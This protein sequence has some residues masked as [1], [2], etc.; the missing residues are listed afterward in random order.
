MRKLY[1]QYFR[2]SENEKV[3]EKVLY[4][5][6]GVT[7]L[8]I[9]LCVVAVDITAYA[10]FSCSISS[11]ENTIKT[12]SFAATSTLESDVYATYGADETY[13]ILDNSENEQERFFVITI[14]K[15]EDSTATTGYCKIKVITDYNDY[16]VQEFY[17]DQIEESCTIMVH[18]PA[19]QAAQVAIIPNWGTCAYEPI[20]DNTVTPEYNEVVK[21]D[22]G[23][24]ETGATTPETEASGETE[25]SSENNP[26]TEETAENSQS[27]TTEQSSESTDTETNKEDGEG[28]DKGLDSPEQQ[29]ET[30]DQSGSDDSPSTD[31]SS[32][33]DQKPDTTDDTVGGN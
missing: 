8:L 9:L 15:S 14:A 23:E 26:P 19:G 21:P 18:V 27:P 33:T 22:S 1:D 11:R 17:T 10:F 6:V 5:R 7:V 20:G 32:D 24:P 3:K 29:T 31:D 25:S 28:A 12:A 13:Y 30:N 16:A 4:T 2:V